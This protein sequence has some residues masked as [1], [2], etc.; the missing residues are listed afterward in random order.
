MREEVIDASQREGGGQVLRLS[1][2]LLAL[3]AEEDKN[4]VDGGSL[5]SCSKIRGGR[6]KPGFR[7][8]HDWGA[9]CSRLGGGEIVSGGV[10]GATEAKVS[11]RGLGAPNGDEAACE[12][13]TAGAVTL[14]LQIAMPCLLEACRRSGEAYS[15][16]FGGGTNVP[17]SPQSCTLTRIAASPQSLHW[18]G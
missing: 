5:V 12:I 7:A 15:V 6:S 11:L 18:H 17:F 16:T 9:P 13:G 4:D 1:L 2:A 8:Q 10:V 3:C 14:M